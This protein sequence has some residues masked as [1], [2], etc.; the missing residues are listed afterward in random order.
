MRDYGFTSYPSMVL[1][2]D[3][4]IVYTHSGQLSYDEL[5]KEIEK[6]K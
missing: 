5:S 3:G 2:K 1:I 6:Y 4:E